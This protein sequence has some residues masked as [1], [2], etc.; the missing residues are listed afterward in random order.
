MEKKELLVEVEKMWEENFS[1]VGV[2]VVKMSIANE[3]LIE[4]DRLPENIR[5]M[6][7]NASIDSTCE[8]YLNGD[9][10]AMWVDH[11]KYMG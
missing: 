2:D 7:V 5:R 10:F 8:V 6:V 9:D 4:E 11:L 3:M 1:P